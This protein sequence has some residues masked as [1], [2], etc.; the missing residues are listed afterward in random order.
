[1]DWRNGE[2]GVVCRHPQNCDRDSIEH[3]HEN[4]STCIG[5]RRRNK[6]ARGLA[7]SKTWRSS[8]GH[9]GRA[10]VLERASS[11]ALFTPREDTRHGQATMRTLRRLVAVECTR[12]LPVAQQPAARSLLGRRVAQAEK[13]VTSRRTPKP[14]PAAAVEC[15]EFS[16]LCAGDSSPSNTRETSTLHHSLFTNPDVPR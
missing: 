1:M 6:S 9:G 11:V 2:E 13:A 5:R 7:Q 14:A 15:G 4:W 16:P 10:S 3:R 12:C 8:S